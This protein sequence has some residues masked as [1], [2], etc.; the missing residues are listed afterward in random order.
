MHLAFLTASGV[1][2]RG[3]ETEPQTHT[4]NPNTKYPSNPVKTLTLSEPTMFRVNADN[5]IK[6]VLLVSEPTRTVDVNTNYA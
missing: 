1:L 4:L 5:R 6:S 2:N 3:P